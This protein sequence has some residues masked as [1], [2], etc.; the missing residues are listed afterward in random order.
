VFIKQYFFESFYQMVELFTINLLNY[1]RLQFVFNVFSKTY[2][3]YLIYEI[4]ITF[5]F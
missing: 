2:E 3:V 1:F 4:V 5:F